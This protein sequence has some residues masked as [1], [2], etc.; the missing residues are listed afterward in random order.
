M[1]LVAGRDLG[2]VPERARQPQRVR[3]LAEAAGLPTRRFAS[4]A[5]AEGLGQL[6]NPYRGSRSLARIHVASMLLVI[7]QITVWTYML[8]W[9]IDDRQWRHAFGIS[10]LWVPGRSSPEM[11]PVVPT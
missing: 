4:R 9:L 7:P 6:A 10:P 11:P 2:N 1:R 8:V 5:E 3:Q